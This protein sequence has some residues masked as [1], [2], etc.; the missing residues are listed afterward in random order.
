[1]T[2]SHNCFYYPTTT[3]FVDDDKNFL[4]TL[5]IQL[6][7]KIPSISFYNSRQAIEYIRKNRTDISISSPLLHENVELSYGMDSNEDM[8]IDISV[9]SLYKTALSS[10]SR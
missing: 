9:S 6:M 4:K 3:V 7:A 1:M 2:E 5:T 10:A 8:K